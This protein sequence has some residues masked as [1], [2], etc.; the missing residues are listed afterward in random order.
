MSDLARLD[1]PIVPA[2]ILGDRFVHGWNPKALA[3]LVGV[4]WVEGERLSSGELA[5]R[6]DRILAATQ[7]L[8]RQVPAEHL[9]MKAPDRDRT[10]RSLGFHVF[11]L[12]LAFRECRERDEFPET[13]LLE[14]PPASL[15]DGAAI[16]G[17]G[18]RVREQ[19]A[20]WCRRP[21][22]CDGFVTTYYGRQHAHEL[23]ERTTWHAA[24]HLRQLYWFLDRMGV[25]PHAPLTDDDL[26]GL[27]F[28]REVWS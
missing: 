16:A 7:R 27:P 26:A 9:E 22:W 14:E 12:S 5:D 4:A 1:I 19:L 10:V 18:E 11:R 24:Q 21:G 15:I 20:E 25:T 28:P 6:L 23:M 2:T 8:M 3:A 17:Y 13:W